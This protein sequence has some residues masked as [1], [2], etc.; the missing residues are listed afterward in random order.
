MSPKAHIV[1]SAV[2]SAVLYPFI[3]ANVEPHGGHARSAD[4]CRYPLD[5]GAVPRKNFIDNAIFDRMAAA[6]I[7]SAPILL[8]AGDFESRARYLNAGKGARQHFD[9]AH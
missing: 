2:A 3:G 1:Q 7:Q 9:R 5:A 8:T 4:P 6:G